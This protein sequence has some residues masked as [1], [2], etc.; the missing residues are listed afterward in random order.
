MKISSNG[1]E[2]IK[3][4]EGFSKWHILTPIT[5]GQLDMVIM[6]N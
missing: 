2:L 5:V 3:K 6:A 4:L 1:I